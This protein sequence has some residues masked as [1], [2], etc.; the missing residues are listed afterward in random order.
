MIRDLA[1]ETDDG[2]ALWWFQGF[3]YVGNNPGSKWWTSLTQQINAANSNLL[4][5]MLTCGLTDNFSWCWDTINIIMFSNNY[6]IHLN[7]NSS[8]RLWIVTTFLSSSYSIL[9]FPVLLFDTGLVE[10]HQSSH[11]NLIVNIVYL[12]PHVRLLPDS[13]LD[14]PVSSTTYSEWQMTNCYNLTVIISG[15]DVFLPPVFGSV[16]FFY[17]R[18]F[19]TF[20]FRLFRLPSSWWIYSCICSRSWSWMW[21]CSCSYCYLHLMVCGKLDFK[22]CKCVWNS[23]V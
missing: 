5:F 2:S 8:S 3:F 13:S 17:L 9:Y 7:L 14:L 20:F 1:E 12:C 15:E 6:K 21:S 22:L 10:C 18:V 23:V 16:S 11:Y 19:N 4:F